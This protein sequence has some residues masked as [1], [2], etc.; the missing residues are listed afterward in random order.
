MQLTL[1]KPLCRLWVAAGVALVL[2][3]AVSQAQFTF[4]TNNG[5]LTITGYTGPGGAV[6]IPDTTNGLPVT[7]IGDEAFRQLHQ[8]TSVTIGANVTNIGTNAFANCTVL[9]N[10]T[11]GASVAS[12]GDDAFYGCL[13]LTGVTIPASVTSIGS[14][15]FGDCL[16]LTAITVATNNPAYSSVA[17]VLFNQSQTTLVEYPAGLGGSYAISSGVTSIADHAFANCTTLSSVTIPAS[18]TS[19][20]SDAFYGCPSLT[21]ITVDTGNPAYSS[22]G[23]G[24]V[25]PE[26][27][28]AHRMSRRPKRVVLDS[29]QRYQHCV[30]CVCFLLPPDRRY[31]RHQRRQYW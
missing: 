29:G 4:T 22:R 1:M 6:T 14:E 21:A 28:H 26:P 2:F 15:V 30:R 9:T 27:N 18:V 3:P 16:D 17:G 5:S 13:S 25:R 10:V 7:S 24:L 12:I 19:I 8:L 23:W 31:H 20:G 11:F